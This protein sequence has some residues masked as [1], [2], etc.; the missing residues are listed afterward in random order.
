[1][2]KVKPIPDDYPSLTAYLMV[3][4]AAAAIAFY[5]KVFGAVERLRMDGGRKNGREE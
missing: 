4:G 1:M 5:Q 2:S 3:D